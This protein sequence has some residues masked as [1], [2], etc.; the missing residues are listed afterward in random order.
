MLFLW[1][2]WSTDYFHLQLQFTVSGDFSVQRHRK[3]GLPKCHRKFLL[4]YNFVYVYTRVYISVLD[5]PWPPSKGR[6]FRMWKHLLNFAQNPI[7]PG[8]RFFIS[9]KLLTRKPQEIHWLQ[10]GL[11]SRMLDFE[12]DISRLQS[13]ISRP[14]NAIFKKP[15]YTNKICLTR[16]KRNE[17]DWKCNQ[18]RSQPLGTQYNNEMDGRHE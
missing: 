4:P 11:D 1:K 8:V 2:L 13:I 16:C 12:S 14:E 7:F 3:F 17:M 6:L 9:S 10:S 15:P 18:A 5:G